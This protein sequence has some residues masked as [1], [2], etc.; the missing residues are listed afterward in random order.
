MTSLYPEDQ[1]TF[2]F[3]NMEKIL[4]FQGSWWSKKYLNIHKQQ[5]ENVEKAG[6]SDYRLSLLLAKLKIFL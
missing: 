3:M 6:K 1:G 4:H 2:K 5:L